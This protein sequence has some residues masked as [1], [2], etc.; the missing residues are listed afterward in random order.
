MILEQL[1]AEEKQNGQVSKNQIPIK[2]WVK[3]YQ[4]KCM[5]L[6]IPWKSDKQLQRFLQQM[7]LNQRDDRINLKD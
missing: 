6:G 5:D 3:L 4:S 7:Q 2:V 1:K